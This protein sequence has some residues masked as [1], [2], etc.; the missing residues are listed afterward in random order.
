[1]IKNELTKAIISFAI[2]F[3][4]FL[5]ATALETLERYSY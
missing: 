4:I 1:M 5:C 3:I 2:I